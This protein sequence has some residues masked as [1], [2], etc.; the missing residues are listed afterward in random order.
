MLTSLSEVW[1][2]L[3]KDIVDPDFHA[4]HGIIMF[5]LLHILKTLSNALEALEYIDE[6]RKNSFLNQIISR[7]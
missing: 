7:K 5:A 2:A 3:C 6:K 1:T 4:H